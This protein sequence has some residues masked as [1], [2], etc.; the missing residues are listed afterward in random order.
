MSRLAVSCV[1]RRM[2]SL[3]GKMK[4]RVVASLFDWIY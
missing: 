1:Q 2:T 4:V 3:N